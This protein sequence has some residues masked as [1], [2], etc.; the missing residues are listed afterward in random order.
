M[1][2]LLDVSMSEIGLVLHNRNLR[3]RNFTFESAY[4]RDKSYLA[5]NCVY[6]SGF[7]VPIGRF[8]TWLIFFTQAAIVMIVTNIRCPCLICK[9]PSIC[10]DCRDLMLL[11]KW[12]DVDQ[13]NY[14]SH[15]TYTGEIE[16][17]QI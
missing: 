13:Y 11:T 4:I 5:T 17:R 6:I 9:Q 14:D 15:V 10:Q 16:G 7:H 12:N 3:P 2:Y 8:Y 1:I